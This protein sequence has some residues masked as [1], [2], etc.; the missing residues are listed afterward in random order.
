MEQTYA[1]EFDEESGCYKIVLLNPDHTVTVLG[2]QWI[3]PAEAEEDI[4]N[5]ILWAGKW[6]EQ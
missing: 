3:D 2:Q 4:S 6:I 1:I 5:I